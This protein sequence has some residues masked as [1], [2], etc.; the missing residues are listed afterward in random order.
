MTECLVCSRRPLCLCLRG[1]AHAASSVETPFS[2]ALP[3]TSNTISPGME[4]APRR[5]P[6]VTRSIRQSGA[7]E[8]R[9]ELRTETRG[10][11]EE[12]TKQ[13]N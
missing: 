5:Q 8:R 2:V 3:R 1:S 13:A 4:G 6:S 10:L 7:E 9:K 12:N 11:P